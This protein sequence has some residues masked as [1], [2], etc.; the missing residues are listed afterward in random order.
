MRPALWLLFAL[1][2]VAALYT[3]NVA[4]FDSTA[5]TIGVRAGAGVLLLG[6]AAGL[7]ATRPGRS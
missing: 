2:L 7:W 3:S 4:D 6:S 5:V 1:A